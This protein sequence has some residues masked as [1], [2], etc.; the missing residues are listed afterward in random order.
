MTTR[1]KAVLACAGAVTGFVAKIA[2]GSREL[3]RVSGVPG[4]GLQ[5]Q[6]AI[7]SQGTL[8]LLYYAGDPERGDLFYLKSMDGG[9][10]FSN[11][12]E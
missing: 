6:V 9:R 4:G 7:D 1:R 10:T 12:F 3:V 11:P 2:A 8:H 5:P